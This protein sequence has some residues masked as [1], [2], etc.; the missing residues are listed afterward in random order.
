MTECIGL[1]GK[2][3]GHNFERMLVKSEPVTL[4]N[5]DSNDM[6]FISFFHGI[7]KKENFAV[8][9]KRCGIQLKKEYN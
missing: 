4:T 9:C 5:I 1:F 2:W 7:P 8:I 3:F 6:E